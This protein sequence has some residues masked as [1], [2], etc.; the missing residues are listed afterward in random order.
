MQFVGM[1]IL[2]VQTSRAYQLFQIPAIKRSGSS[3]MSYIISALEPSGVSLSE[4]SANMK[5]VMT[6]GTKEVTVMITNSE[7]FLPSTIS[8]RLH[9]DFIIPRKSPYRIFR[10]RPS[11]IILIS[12][13]PVCF[14]RI[15]L[16]F[17]LTDP[18]R[19]YERL[20]MRPPGR[21]RTIHSQTAGFQHQPTISPVAA[22]GRA[23]RIR[24]TCTES[25]GPAV[26]WDRRYTRRDRSGARYAPRC[27]E[28][29]SAGI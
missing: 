14:G 11:I 20:A 22:Q 4:I 28:T 5:A 12:I 8:L 26:F 6:V 18:V 24:G 21:C 7:S 9:L 10:L 3:T 23:A 15:L 2:E 29:A 1:I 16:T 13:I 19:K 27:K 17:L 25:T